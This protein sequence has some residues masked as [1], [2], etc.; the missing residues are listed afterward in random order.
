MKI[1]ITEKLDKT[2][3]GFK[4][5]PIVQSC[6]QLINIP[7][8]ACEYF[9]IDECIDQIKDKDILKE[10]YTKIRKDGVISVIGKDINLLCQ[11]L[12]TRTINEE[13][14]SEYA[15]NQKQL[16]SLDRIINE[17]KL[18]G[19]TIINSS[20]QGLNYEVSATRQKN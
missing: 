19:L 9:V 5:L 6:V 2:I 10:I 20:I 4:V 3:D 8:N 16:W 18:C 17:L 13:Q 11:A 14:F 15:T 12:T 7:R 1:L